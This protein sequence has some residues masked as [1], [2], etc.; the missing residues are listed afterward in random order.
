MITPTQVTG[1]IA[2]IELER[3]NLSRGDRVLDIGCAQGYA[4]VGLAKKGCTAFGI[5]VIPELVQRAQRNIVEANV[6]AFPILA[7]GEALPFV[8]GAFDAVICIEVLEHIPDAEIVLTEIRRV[9]KQGGRLC[10][11]VPTWYTE[12]LF[13]QLD[14]NFAAYSGHVRIFR[15]REITSLL[16]RYGFQILRKEGKYFEWSVYW[17]FRSLFLKTDPICYM[18]VQ[19]YERLDYY[20]KRI[21]RLAEKLGI[22]KI[23]K[24]VGNRIFPKSDYF[25]CERL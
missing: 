15:R 20:Y 16:A 24:F 10:L 18:Y 22:G 9:L 17:L 12:K 23:V 2:E 11:A 6:T 14:K 25:Y 19:R 13:G 3:L 1:K 7:S 5:D 21:W 8:D 4:L